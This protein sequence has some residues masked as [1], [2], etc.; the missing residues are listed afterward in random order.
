M[1]SITKIDKIIL[2]VI[3]ITCLIS[4]IYLYVIE[5]NNANSNKN[6]KVVIQVQGKVIKEIPLN[7][8]EKNKIYKFTFNSN[9]GYIE[10]KNKSVRILDMDKKICPK[11]ICSNTGWISNKYQLI[12]CLPNKIVVSI[13]SIKDGAIDAVS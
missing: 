13:K 7:K 6:E 1:K 8:N 5:N 10:I 3:L 4:S 9:N 11:G 12:V 2:S